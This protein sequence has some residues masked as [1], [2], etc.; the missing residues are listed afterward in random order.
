M[1]NL[2]EWCIRVYFEITSIL[3][4]VIGFISL[5]SL[6]WKRTTGEI[7]KIVW[8]WRWRNEFVNGPLEEAITM[9]SH[10]QGIGSKLL[11][12]ATY[13][14]LRISPSH[15]S[16]Q[17]YLQHTPSVRQNAAHKNYSKIKH[18]HITN[19]KSEM[20]HPLHLY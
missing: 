11:H 13:Y 2:V 10:Y 17:I 8:K 12:C 4:T 5:F 15:Y 1:D 20:L 6:E 19:H 16:L 14:V 7:M 9:A 3:V 18:T